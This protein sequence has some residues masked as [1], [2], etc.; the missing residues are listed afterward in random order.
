MG[1]LAVVWFALPVCAFVAMFLAMI[2]AWPK[3]RF[4]AEARRALL[5]IEV[6]GASLLLPWF[7]SGVPHSKSAR[8]ELVCWLL[9]FFS[10][11]GGATVA[12]LARG[13]DAPRWRLR[14]WHVPQVFWLLAVLTDVGRS[15]IKE[16][17]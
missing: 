5:R 3:N 13:V 4:S 9:G 1:A 16:M 12:W 14:A 8:V 17:M 15:G 2:V 10:V 6:V 7:V 11:A